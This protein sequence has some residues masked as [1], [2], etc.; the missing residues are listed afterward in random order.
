MLNSEP[1]DAVCDATRGDSS[2]TV[3]T[4]KKEIQNVS[5]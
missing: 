1:K 2:T 4:I 5:L 3:D